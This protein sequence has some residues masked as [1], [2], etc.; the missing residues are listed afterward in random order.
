MVPPEVASQKVT[1]ETVQ[2]L[3]GF[4]LQSSAHDE[5]VTTGGKV[6]RESAVSL[7]WKDRDHWE[8]ESLTDG[9]PT[10]HWLVNEGSAWESL[11]GGLLTLKGDP[12]PLRAQLGLAWDPWED[13]VALTGGRIQYGAG[14]PETVD[15]RAAV[16]HD[17]SLAPAATVVAHRSFG[18]AME[19]VALSGT[20]W[21]DSETA[22]RLLADVTVQSATPGDASRS[23]TFNVKLAVTGLGQDPGVAVPPAASPLPGAP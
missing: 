16:R 12:E 10:T 9:R 21:I 17:V 23:R 3:G 5:R 20:V 13:V 6:L 11:S 19:P 1:F 8:Y 15:G 4:T 2:D 7:K 18:P 22:V 14:V